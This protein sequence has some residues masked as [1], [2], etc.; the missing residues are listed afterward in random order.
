M[1]FVRKVEYSLIRC[2]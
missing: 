2:R 1:V